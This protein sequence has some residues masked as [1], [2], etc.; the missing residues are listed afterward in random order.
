MSNERME[1]FSVKNKLGAN[2]I[3]F[4]LNCI[5]NA[6][7]FPGC[8]KASRQNLFKLKYEFL[9]DGKLFHMVTD[10]LPEIIKEKS[11]DPVQFQEA[12]VKTLIKNYE[13][14]RANY[15]YKKNIFMNPNA[16]PLNILGVTKENTTK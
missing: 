14:K 13:N 7:Y 16:H 1:D 2:C 10:L 8:N 15:L 3:W 9:T 11:F 4:G 5:L 6:T 12:C